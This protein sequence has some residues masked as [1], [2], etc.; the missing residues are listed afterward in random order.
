MDFHICPTHALSTAGTKFWVLS[1]WYSEVPKKC[2]GNERLHSDCT[3]IIIPNWIQSLGVIFLVTEYLLY[4]V[5]SMHLCPRSGYLTFSPLWR[6]PTFFSWSFFVYCSM[7]VSWMTRMSSNFIPSPKRV[8]M[9]LYFRDMFLHSHPLFRA[10]T[11]EIFVLQKPA[12]CKHIF[13]WTPS[14]LMQ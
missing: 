13:G 14:T 5:R 3:E 10:K 7:R 8:S 9:P 4:L 11:S 6:N 2:R 1:E 12:W